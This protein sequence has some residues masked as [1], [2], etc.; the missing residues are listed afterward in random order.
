MNV[1]ALN[2]EFMERSLEAWDSVDKDRWIYSFDTED[3]II[4]DFDKPAGGKAKRTKEDDLFEMLGEEREEE[5][6]EL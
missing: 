6:V 2:R 5:D 3:S 4:P 1:D